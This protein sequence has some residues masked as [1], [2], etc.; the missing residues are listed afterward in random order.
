MSK[1]KHANEPGKKGPPFEPDKELPAKPDVD[2][3]PTKK[4]IKVPEK[5][6]PTRIEEPHKVDPTRINNPPEEKPEKP[7]NKKA[8]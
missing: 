1:K 6:D 4:I 3:D 7:G 2:P 5:T 8:G